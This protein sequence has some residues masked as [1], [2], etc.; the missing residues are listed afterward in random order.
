MNLKSSWAINTFIWKRLA[1]KLNWVFWV[2][3]SLLILGSNLALLAHFLIFQLKKSLANFF[4]VVVKSLT[5][6]LIIV[7]LVALPAQASF[8]KSIDTQKV[9]ILS[10]ERSAKNYWEY[11]VQLSVDRTV[12]PRT[13][14]N[15]R[16][17]LWL[18]TNGQWIKFKDS[19]VN[20]VA[21][22]LFPRY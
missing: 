3:D 5:I 7:F 19:S 22:S 10:I 2:T 8:C 15:C 16:E 11:Q 17:K 12:Q 13:V 1:K 18:Q 14:Y 4:L 9:C 21:C 20:A 6:L